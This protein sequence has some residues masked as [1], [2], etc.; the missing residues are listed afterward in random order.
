MGNILVTI[1]EVLYWVFFLLILAR[2]I[3]S[4]INGYYEIR[5]LVFRITEPV[6][7]PVRRIL[8]PMGGFDLSPIIVLLVANLLK[9]VLQS[10]VV[11][12]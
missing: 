12:L 10:F 5:D 2:I 7:A 8:P 1:L 3:L 9:R 6:L 11:S 4:Y